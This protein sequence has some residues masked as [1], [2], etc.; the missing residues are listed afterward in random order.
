MVQVSPGV[1]DTLERLHDD[2]AGLIGLVL[3]ERTALLLHPLEF[4]LFFLQQL[5]HFL[6]SIDFV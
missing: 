4:F 2:G 5:F 6:K 1:I 3:D